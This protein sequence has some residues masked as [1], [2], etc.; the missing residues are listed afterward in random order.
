MTHP[1]RTPTQRPP[2]D[3]AAALRAALDEWAAHEWP[4]R[5]TVAFS[6]GLDS[7]VLL[8]ALCR[9]GLPARVRAAHVDH[10]LHA[11]SPAW[12]AHCATTAEALGAEFVAVRVA[13]DR[14]SRQGLEAAAREARYRALGELLAPGEWLLTA[15]HGDDQLE[16]L[17]LRLVRGT[18]V[19]GLRGIIAFGPF[20]AG[21]LGRPLLRF[22][23]E[24]LRAQ[25]LAWELA[26]LEDPSNRDQR[27]DRNFL[28]LHVLPALLERWPT[29]AQQAERLAAQ[30]SEAEQLLDGVAAQ[31]SEALTAPW[32][33][34]RA[35]LAALE[36]A[37]Q[38]N[39]LRYLI[40]VVGL[41]TP[42]AR[43]LEELRAALLDARA[44][45]SAL[46]RWP[47]GD[48]RIFRDALYLLAPLPPP[49]GSELAAHLGRGDR[50]TG[51]EGRLELVPARDGAGLPESWLAEGLTL[52]F[53]SGGERFRPRGRPH[54]HTLKHL[55][56]E[57]GVV[58]WMRNRVPLLTRGD[59]L[60]AIGD[61]WLS[62]DVD[63]AAAHEP[64]WRVQWTNHPAVRA[65]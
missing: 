59:V 62:A 23:R 41:G 64:R 4:P 35:V 50:W 46:V 51:P 38:R 18:G 5:L 45:S 9:L 24:Q 13:V 63:A 2:E 12:S 47:G 11:Q 7:T 55:F 60:V 34:P 20:A 57:G 40:R 37:R 33:V 58:P 52:R 6:G 27:H 22:T 1:D 54:H 53:R 3:L 42:S 26:W 8:A 15:H 10:G 19:R 21:F 56:Q 28:R 61:L 29:A 30:M 14:A 32:H 25:A 31:D 65:P 39:L 43:K 49:S 48:G 17:L 44:G 16:T 36:P